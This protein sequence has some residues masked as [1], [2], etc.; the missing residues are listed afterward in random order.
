MNIITKYALPVVFAVSTTLYAGEN[1][2]DDISLPLSE[3]NLEYSVKILDFYYKDVDHYVKE[4][5]KEY[6]LA[7]N[8]G[9]LNVEVQKSIFESLKFGLRDIKRIKAFSEKLPNNE[10]YQSLALS[11]EN[12]NLYK[13]LRKNVYGLDVG[14]REL[15][16]ELRA[17][18]LDVEVEKIPRNKDVVFISFALTLCSVFFG[19]SGLLNAYEKKVKKWNQ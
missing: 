18:G 1:K 15:E 5:E 2:L 9:Y 11:E 12:T 6:N 17:N 14:T 4:A 8:L 16:K 10:K 7:V 19:G 3:K 13:L